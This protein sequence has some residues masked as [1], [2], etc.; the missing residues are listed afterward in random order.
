MLGLPTGANNLQPTSAEAFCMTPSE[1]G[2]VANP[3]KEMYLVVLLIII[4]LVANLYISF[5][6]LHEV[7]FA[8]TLIVT[9]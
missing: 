6:R 7:L 3:I 9:R 8:S 5:Y 2:I 1:Q 4:C